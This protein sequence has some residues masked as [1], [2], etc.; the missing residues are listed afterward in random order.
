[1]DGPDWFSMAS[2]AR[3]AR[4]SNTLR[5][6]LSPLVWMASF[7]RKLT[8]NGSNSRWND[9]CQII[10]HPSIIHP[11]HDE[12][13][14]LIHLGFIS[15]P[16]P[17]YKRPRL[18]APSLI[19][20]LS[21]PRGA[22]ESNMEEISEMEAE[23]Q[24]KFSELDLVSIRFASMLCDLC[25]SDLCFADSLSWTKRCRKTWSRSPFLPYSL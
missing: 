15:T 23:S 7:S 10:S 13:P 14:K 11:Q 8:I 20:S 19:V 21:R 9:S 3:V 18:P 25:V 5:F 6:P 1:M 4:N 22:K 24:V 12:R 17:P 2:H 16:S